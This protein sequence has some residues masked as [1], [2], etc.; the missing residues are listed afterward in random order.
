MAGEGE[1]E[2][3]WQSSTF[4][5]HVVQEVRDAVHDVVKELEGDKFLV[6]SIVGGMVSFS[7]AAGRDIGII[8][9]QFSHSNVIIS[10][11]R[12]KKPN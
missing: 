1:G 5:S 9:V 4:H 6:V 12:A 3:Q 8:S 2:P 10:K 11:N 7:M